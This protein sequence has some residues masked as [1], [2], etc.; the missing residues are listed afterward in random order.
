MLKSI[1]YCLSCGKQVPV[2]LQ[3]KCMQITSNRSVSEYYKNSKIRPRPVDG[4]YSKDQQQRKSCSLHNFSCE[5]LGASMVKITHVPTGDK[6]TLGCCP[7]CPM[8]F[9]ENI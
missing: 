1:D 6:A 3:C 8:C 4:D 2:G 9:C 5:H 7:N